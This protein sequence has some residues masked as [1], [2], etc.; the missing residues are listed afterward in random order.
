MDVVTA[1]SAM[2][3][4]LLVSGPEIGHVSLAGL[5]VRIHPAPA[6]SQC[7]LIADDPR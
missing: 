3:A 1:G 4:S 7:E 2:A 6:V 5:E